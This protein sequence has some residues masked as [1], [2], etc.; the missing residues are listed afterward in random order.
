MQQVLFH[1]PIRAEWLPEGFPFPLL[2]LLVGLAVGFAARWAGQRQSREWLRETLATLSNAAFL[3]GVVGALL[4]YF[5]APRLPDG[6]PIYG[7][8]MMLFLAFIF[9]TWLG[10]LRAERLGIPQ[11][12]IQDLAIW[13]FICGL[14]G[15]RAASMSERHPITSA[16]FYKEFPTIWDGGIILYGGIIGGLFGYLGAWYFIF[17][18]Q[19]TPTLVL[20]DV[21]APSIA[22]GI[23][24]GRIGC[25]LNGCCYGFVACAAC[26]VCPVHFPLS[27]PP[28]GRLV[29]AGYQTVAGFTLDDRD[30]PGKGVRVGEVDPASPAYANGLRPGDVIV[31]AD[32]GS[33]SSVEDLLG[34]SDPPQGIDRPGFNNWPKGKNDLRLTV[35][36]G[37]E[38]VDVPPF[39]PRTL[40]LYPTQLY[41]SISM[42][43]LIFVL[44]AYE[45]L[46][47]RPGQ[48]MAILM[49]GYA[50]HRSLNELLRDDP[51]PKGFEF[52]TS[53]IL[54]GAG[55]ALW[56]YL[57][58][59]P[60]RRTEPVPAKD[61]KSLGT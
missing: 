44:L 12:N 14:I 52:Y 34:R 29:A 39:S 33:I 47:H 11:Q 31:G 26:P 57:A 48:L 55:L 28:T 22:L 51:R 24:L 53:F 37:G 21:M 25:F 3:L 54:L 36:R 16:E 56:L 2:V 13:L 35:V 9:C 23:C 18:K 60:A 43:L 61:A 59:T 50:G 27:A 38:T 19:R 42:L 30:Q 17:R 15:A 4:T 45:P 8:G 10:G 1:I 40:G 7:Y 46:R 6:I 32:W 5:L 20:A 49:M 41:E 58:L